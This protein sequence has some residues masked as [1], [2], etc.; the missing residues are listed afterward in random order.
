MGEKYLHG[1][2]FFNNCSPQ[3]RFGKGKKLLNRLSGAIHAK[4]ER[5][6]KME[7]KHLFQLEIVFTQE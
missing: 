1:R 4:E 2:K 7:G 3:I 6:E 5:G